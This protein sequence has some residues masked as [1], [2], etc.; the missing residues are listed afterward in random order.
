[1]TARS[2]RS[3]RRSFQDGGAYPAIG[4]F[5]PFFTRSMAQGVY[6]IP[7]V[8]LNSSAS[9][10]TPRR[11]RAY[12]GAGRPEATRLLERILDI[13]RRRARHG[14]GRDPAAELHPARGVPLTTVTGAN[15]D[16]GDYEHGARRGVS[17]RRLRRPA[18][19]AGRPG[20]PAATS[21]S[22]GSACP[23]YVEV[24]GRRGLPGVRRGRRSTTTGRST[25]GRR[26]LRP[27]TGPRDRVRDDR[28]RSCSASRWSR[29]TL[30][31]VGH[32]RWSRGGRAPMDRG[33]SRSAAA[34]CAGRARRCS[35]QAKPAGRPPARGRPRRHRASPT[36]AGPRRGRGA[37]V[38]ARRGPSS[39]R[40]RPRTPAGPRAWSPGWPRRSTSNRARR[41][42]RSAR[43]SPWWRSTSETGRARLRP[44]RRGRR[45][46]SRPQ[47]A[48]RGG[49]AARRDGPGRGAGAVGAGRLR[50]GRQPAHREP[51]GLRASRARPSCRASSWPTPRR[52][53]R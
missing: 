31:A 14:P 50:R 40:L 34:R 35:T 22:S 42:S 19:R 37:G 27:R 41:R 33:R 17:R 52:R 18:R 51:H 39:P 1:M 10:P 29:S 6:A 7:K 24:T 49:P 43:T 2:R 32:R 16:V 45:L 44:P 30:R 28:R 9:P 5:L 25:T 38:G 23:C 21:S 20:G 13:G 11:S 8:E 46:R 15:Y 3:G 4:A 26:H 47:P 48:A 53:R 12:R 36:T